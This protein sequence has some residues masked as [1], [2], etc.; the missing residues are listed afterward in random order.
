[1]IE[2][3]HGVS[4]YSG[5]WGRWYGWASKGDRHLEGPVRFSRLHARLDAWR[6]ARRLS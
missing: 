3:V 5:V 6:L 4:V 2:V 1:M